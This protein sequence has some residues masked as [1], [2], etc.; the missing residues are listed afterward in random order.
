MRRKLTGNWISLLGAGVATG[1]LALVFD[2]PRQ[3]LAQ[4]SN[5]R[6]PGEIVGVSIPEDARLFLS[7]D[8]LVYNNDTGVV[9]A[10]GAVRI[11]YGGFRMVGD[12]VE[13]DQNNGR[14]K[15]FGRVEL[16]EPDGNRFY[17]EELDIT[18][19][20]GDGFVNALRVETTDN[21]RIVAESGRR[22]NGNQ[23]RF[24][25]GVYTACNLCE[26]NPEKAPLWQIKSR[27]VIQ[28]DET[29]TIRLE[30]ARFEFAGV[31]L[32]YVPFF[33]VPDPTVKRKSGF[34]FPLFR[35]ADNL[36]GGLGIPYYHVISPH[37]DATLTPTIYTRQGLLVEGEIRNQ[38]RNGYHTF[39]FAGIDQQDSGR[40][41]NGTVDEETNGRFFMASEAEFNINSRWIFGWDFMVQSDRNFA[42]TYSIS[43]YSD[44]VI[45]S[46]AYLAGLTGRN[47]FEVRGYYF[48]I[49][50]NRST[51]L[52]EDEQPIVH[53]V[54]DYAYTLED[55]VFGG[56]VDFDANFTSLSRDEDDIRDVSGFGDR[57]YGLEGSSARFSA[58]VEWRRAFIAASGFVMTPILAGRGDG[59]F[60]SVDDPGPTYP[61][62]FSDNDT[63]ARGM[64]T[65]GLEARYP[66]LATTSS[67]RH[68]FEPVAQ[69]FVRPD[70][71]L[72]GGL[73]NEDAQSFVFDA[74]SL[75][76]RDKFS[77]YDRMEGG[78]RANL[79][80][81]YTGNF[82]S[83]TSF[84]L[85][86]GQ[87]YHIG[88]QNSFD[89]EDL[90]KTGIDSGLETD[91]SDF[92]GLA[93][94]D[95]P[96]GFSMT[97]GGR[98]DEDT[99]EMRRTDLTA[100]YT[101]ANLFTS[102]TY[103]Q[104]DRQPLDD[105]LSRRE[106]VI[107][108]ASVALNT[109]WRALGNVTYDIADTEVTRYGFGIGYEDECFI[110]TL[111]YTENSSSSST[112][113]NRF[114]IGARLSFR[115]LGDIEIGNGNNRGF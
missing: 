100:S 25:N 70:E 97:A 79:G 44:E 50:E 68:V 24:T 48:D 52:R 107:G 19:D 57:F 35:Y 95:F 71:R 92:V 34:L 55:P 86:G 38:F 61:G 89:T 33:S 115:T 105:D 6:D 60:L 39:Q 22:S 43:G 20:F 114:T 13:Y 66:L 9:I 113:A 88:G 73:P 91:A 14:L 41:E 26:E 80:F 58:V 112:D 51:D 49:Q 29:R 36:G 106:E 40:F 5:E 23:T 30:N 28:D 54:V 11:E 2:V 15:A 21:T 45:R 56:E 69:V 82:N 12:R 108:R 62:N 37:M 1:A 103:S 93:T 42:R 32:A 77:G 67:S 81:R 94:L 111:D 75:F 104:I 102:L 99:F 63:E 83:G 31:P 84:R 85:I 76:Q 72:A 59:H 101:T 110:F 96:N 17:A 10:R 87:S 8:E 18:D 90:A 3:A 53:P 4:A 74:T 27:R 16:V 65:A 98:F 78:T 46:Q 64:A 7:A 47:S 109:N